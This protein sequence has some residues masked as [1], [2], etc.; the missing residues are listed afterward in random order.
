MRVRINDGEPDFGWSKSDI[1]YWLRKHG[2]ENEAVDNDS[3]HLKQQGAA[4][5]IEGNRQASSVC[6]NSS[7][8]AGR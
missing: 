8:D 2:V 3:S 1:A 5:P 4:G 6:G 7:N